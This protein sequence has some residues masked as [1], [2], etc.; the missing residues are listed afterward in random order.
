MYDFWNE[1][2]IDSASNQ[3]INE[4]LVVNPTQTIDILKPMEDFETNNL[5]LVK[6]KF[7]KTINFDHF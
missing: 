1:D 2:E 7:S 3:Y 6:H 5:D 4:L